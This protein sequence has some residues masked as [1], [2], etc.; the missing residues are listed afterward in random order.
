MSVAMIQKILWW[1]VIGRHGHCSLLSQAS[2]YLPLI[3][4]ADNGFK[5][6]LFRVLGQLG[7]TGHEAN[8]YGEEKAQFKGIGAEEGG[9]VSLFFH[10]VSYT[11]I[12][13]AARDSV[14]F[15]KL[16]FAGAEGLDFLL[17]NRGDT[18]FGEINFIGGNLH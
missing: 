1:S 2:V 11:I 8:A 15:S 16:F 17:K 10:I 9:F 18:G 6:K 12:L 5:L 3:P 7:N 14:R 13:T 4:K